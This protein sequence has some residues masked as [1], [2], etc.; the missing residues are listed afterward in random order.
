MRFI[1]AGRIGYGTLITRDTGGSVAVMYSKDINPR[2]AEDTNLFLASPDLLKALEDAMSELADNFR[3]LRDTQ[4]SAGRINAASK[5]L[6]QATAAIAKA[7][8]AP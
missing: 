3:Y 5:V 8:G 6:E 1:N 2:A 7:K 4:A